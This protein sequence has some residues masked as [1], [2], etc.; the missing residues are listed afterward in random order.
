MQDILGVD[1]LTIS[2]AVAFTLGLGARMVTMPPM[3]GFLLA[4]FVLAALGVESDQ[5]LEHIADMGVLLLL[6]TIGLKL[7]IRSLFK[8]PIIGTATIHMGVWVLIVG[9]L[10]FLIAVVGVGRYAGLDWAQVAIL[11]F[12]LSFSSTVFAVKIFDEKGELGSVHG[13]T[14]VG[15]LI[16]QDI[17]AAIFLT[18]AGG[19]MPS[20]WAFALIALLVLRP[21]LFAVL[22][23]IGHGEMLP[24]FGF[25]ALIVLGVASFKLV[26]LKP[27]LGALVLGMM[28]ADH[29]RAPEVA[30][31][32]F[33]FKE[34]FLIGFFLQ[35]G[36][37]G[38]PSWDLLITAFALMGLL[39]VKCFGFFFLLVLFHLRARTALLGALG[40]STYS[41]FGLIV[42]D[43]AV[44]DG[45]L[46]PDWLTT[47]ALAVA[48]SFL[49]LSPVNAM[50]HSIYAKLT[51]R[52]RRFE[53]RNVDADDER[54][55][56]GDAS[57]V[58]FGMG[59]LGQS[60]YRR[61]HASHGD[62]L[63]GVET[64]PQR[65]TDLQ[66][67]GWNVM[68]GDATDSDFWYRASRTG[69]TAR[70]VLLAM[71]E[72]RANLYALEQIRGQGFTGY[73]A[74]MARYPDEVERLRAAGANFALDLFGEA[75][76]GFAD[77]V[78]E[79]LRSVNLDADWDQGDRRLAAPI[80]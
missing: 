55:R 22:N 30:D 48:M 72:H 58:I 40:L 71:P 76:A 70:A 41:E 24:L 4:G 38:V 2:L 7:Q 42:G 10:F 13:R 53:Y 63:V 51:R 26:G 74:A 52:L 66:A 16:F 18:A 31:S 32:L 21:V 5:R 1:S 79:R 17:A 60:I 45:L 6:F 37:Q 9:T 75:G 23:R 3:V 49:V 33:G 29:R 78:D 35:I 27:D 47:I 14:A 54:L 20:L 77:D 19:Q 39:L 59:R 44:K 67:R 8:W 15:V 65:V 62:N 57:I 43:V 68:H 25:F 56:T 36:L 34:L 11:A 12:A 64:D 50:G 61:L 46:H 28:L 69:A 73:I 80:D